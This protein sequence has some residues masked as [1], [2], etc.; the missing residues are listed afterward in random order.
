LI[1]RKKIEGKR[2]HELAPKNFGLKEI[3]KGGGGGPCT[4]FQNIEAM[5]VNLVVE[6]N[7]KKNR[8]GGTNADE[9]DGK[10]R[11]FDINRFQLFA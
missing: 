6:S 2:S 8:R 5:G 7:E 10:K 1:K 4:G 3:Q 9:P 11:E